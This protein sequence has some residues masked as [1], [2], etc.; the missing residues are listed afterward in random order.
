MKQK[1][2]QFLQGNSRSAKV[3]KN[4]LISMAV[5]GIS[6]LTTLVLMPLTLG[7]L[8]KY[9]FGI[10]ATLSSIL[11]WMN[12]F[13]IGLSCGLRNRLAEALAKEDYKLGQVYVSTT[14]FFLTIL[15]LIMY[16]TFLIVNPWLNWYRILNVPNGYIEGLNSL[17]WIIFTLFSLNFVLKFINMIY[18]AKQMP[19]F[20]NLFILCTDLLSLSIIFIL[21]LYTK[22]DLAKV[23][24]TY[25]ITPVIVFSVAILYT[26]FYKY[27]EL[28]PR[29]SAIKLKYGK[30][31]MSLGMQYFIIQMTCIVIF[32]S[33]NILISQIINPG[34]VTIY[35]FA[36]K[37][38]N[39]L[40]TL[41]Y[42]MI[43]PLWSATT[44][45]YV[46]GE[47]DWI[48]N[49]I[50]KMTRVWMAMC[51]ITAIMLIGS[52]LAYHLWIGDKIHIPFS[53][54][55][56]VA[57]YMCILNWNNLYSFFVNGIGKIRL[58]LYTSLF[59][60]A[61]FIPLAIFLGKRWEI[62]GILGAM[63]ISLLPSAVLLFIQY[64]KI[65]NNRA[66]GIWNR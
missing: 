51:G 40:T 53:I 39:V 1:L 2:R 45:A 61:S 43:S 30:D 29:F 20:G 22:G 10:W 56:A 6:I 36:F 12:Y 65:I 50:M 62:I 59:T 9:Q 38:F 25:S 58:Q 16:T 46:K 44:D 35:N 8:N 34:E 18:T 11:M 17:V 32:S 54:S 13:D 19:V 3:K 60:G 66:Y 55:I 23:A 15:M 28:R 63:C 64:R 14:L 48:R 47:M 33:A 5:K 27:K 52:P 21:T 41:F 26:F 24:I 57:I 49:S 42:I 37:Y 4:V 7:Y 31:L